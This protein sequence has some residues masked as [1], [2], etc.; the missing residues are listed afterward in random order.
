MLGGVLGS[1]ALA[2]DRPG[3]GATYRYAPADVLTPGPPPG[4]GGP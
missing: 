3:D 1:G 2:V 4:R